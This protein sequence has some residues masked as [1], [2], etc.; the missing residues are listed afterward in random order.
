MMNNRPDFRKITSNISS[1]YRW[2]A[3]SK[4]LVN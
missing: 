4:E 3:K 2:V 1:I